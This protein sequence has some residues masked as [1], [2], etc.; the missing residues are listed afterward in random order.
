VPHPAHLANSG[1]RGSSRAGTNWL[2]GLWSSHRQAAAT[3][4]YAYASN[5]PL[6]N[7]D[8]LGLFSFGSLVSDVVH[9]VK[10]AING[11]K[12]AAHAVTG[13]VM[14]GAHILASSTAIASG[15]KAL[16]SGN[17][18][19]APSGVPVGFK[20]SAERVTEEARRLT[21]ATELTSEDRSFLEKILEFCALGTGKLHRYLWFVGD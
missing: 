5:N 21:Q 18:L 7:V 4:P 2:R 6:N 16:T 3:S 12:H 9:V 17:W 19:T 8:S 15:M 20:R 11:A 13:A 10:H 1:E 14:R